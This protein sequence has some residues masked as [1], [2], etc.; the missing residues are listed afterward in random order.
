MSWEEQKTDVKEQE[1]KKP[2]IEFKNFNEADKNR[3]FK[4]GIYGG[5]ATGKTHFC[6]TCPEPIFII[7][8]EMGA[9]PLAHQFKGKD[10]KILDICEADGVLSYEKYVEAV[11]FLGEQKNI[12]TIIIDS[13]TDIWN[14]CQEYGKV[15]VFKIKPEQRLAQQWDWGVINKLYL[16]PLLSL[17]NINSNL[18]LTAREQEVY[19]SAGNPSGIINPHWM[20]KTS[21]WMDYVIH[22]TKK[23][24]KMNNVDFSTVIDKS[25]AVMKLMGKRFDNLDF[26]N[27]KVEVDKNKEVKE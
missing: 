2:Q 19:N 11:K 9:S 24:N 1:E 18:I 17:I 26:E 7:D 22:N 12:G 13:A 8:T 16:K 3:G 14:F 25:R 20:K 10:I 6:L 5:F 27:F 23:I 4:I 21:Y 15:K